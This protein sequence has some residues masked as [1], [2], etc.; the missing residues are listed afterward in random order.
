MAWG[1]EDWTGLWP[2]YLSEKL[3]NPLDQT[4]WPILPSTVYINVLLFSAIF[5]HSQIQEEYFIPM[6][7]P[8]P[9]WKI[10][11]KGFVHIGDKHPKGWLSIRH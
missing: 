8:F 6:F 9:L 1:T 4:V 3:L 11:P 10:I 2:P 7:W 5:S